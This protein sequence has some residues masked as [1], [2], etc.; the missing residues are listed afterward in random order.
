MQRKINATL[1][2]WHVESKN[3]EFIKT[4]SEMIAAQIKQD[5]KKWVMHKA[6]N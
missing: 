5:S 2:H 6:N 4:E 1:S 3:V